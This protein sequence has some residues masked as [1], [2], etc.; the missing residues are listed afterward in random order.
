VRSFGTAK[1]ITRPATSRSETARDTIN[2]FPIFLRLRSVATATQTRILPATDR[3]IRNAKNRPE[4]KAPNV[5]LRLDKIT[6]HIM[7]YTIPAA[8]LKRDSLS[9]ERFKVPILTRYRFTID[10]TA[11]IIHA[12]K[13]G[14]KDSSAAIK[15]ARSRF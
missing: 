6:T 14:V 4:K 10:I 2:R 7:V 12:G 8:R 3:N 13:I 11:P 5:A 9:S 15:T 1:T